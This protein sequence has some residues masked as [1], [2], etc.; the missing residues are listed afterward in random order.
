MKLRPMTPQEVVIDRLRRIKQC[1]LDEKT[2]EA[3]EI[4]LDLRDFINTCDITRKP[5]FD[6]DC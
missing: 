3:F 1:F 6:K 4:L 2:H 5:D